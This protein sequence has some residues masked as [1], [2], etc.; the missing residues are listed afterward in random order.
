MAAAAPQPVVVVVASLAE[1]AARALVWQPS[2][3]Q[4]PV[5]ARLERQ[6]QVSSPAWELLLQPAQVRAS[7]W[8]APE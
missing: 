1:P 8:P 4:E 7:A 6:A 3:Q 5:Q 2:S